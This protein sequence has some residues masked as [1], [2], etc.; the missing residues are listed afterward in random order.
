MDILSF[1]TIILLLFIIVGAYLIVTNQTEG[2]E[3]IILIV[4]VLISLIYIFMNL[5]IFNS[6][7][8]TNSIPVN[9]YNI[10]KLTTVDTTSSSF[11][12]S[13]W[14]YISEWDYGSKK[15][16]FSM[17]N[18]KGI[19]NPSIILAPSTN[20]LIIKYYTSPS[21]TDITN[22]SSIETA[23]TNK[24]IAKTNL[25]AALQRYKTA[26]YAFINASN[27]EIDTP[28]PQTTAATLTAIDELIASRKAYDGGSTTNY[29][30]FTPNSNN[31]QTVY[32]KGIKNIDATKISA[33]VKEYSAKNGTLF[34]N[35][36]LFETFKDL[37]A[38]TITERDSESVTIVDITMPIPNDA[39]YRYNDYDNIAAG[40]IYNE[41]AFTKVNYITYL[42]DK[43]AYYNTSSLYNYVTKLSTLKSLTL[44]TT[45]NVIGNYSLEKITIKDISIQNWVNV[46]VSFGDNKVNTHI[47]GKL[48]DS[49]VSAGSAQV[50]TT[51]AKNSTLSWGGYTGYISASRYYP[52]FLTIREA[53]NIYKEGF[54]DNLMGDFLNQYNA[55]ITF[56]KNQIEKVSFP[57]I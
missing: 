53:L 31:Y 49:H 48:V 10:K 17:T 45:E 35:T 18:D 51:T 28:T 23:R 36:M 4:A 27:A 12:L 40:I 41:R 54:S 26:K 22:K 6:Y 3:K 25:E 56:S 21:N 32:G 2:R 24:N 55:K 11:S 39:L 34:S 8:E 33:Y 44:N 7:T 1:T 37:T 57:L 52:R 13:T 38:N 19:Y 42:T 43:H 20:D 46:V 47:N 5:G 50:V 14:M 9:A 16:L 30:D 29:D 15:T